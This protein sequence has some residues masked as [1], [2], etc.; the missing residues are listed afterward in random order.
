VR[1]QL[2]NNGAIRTFDNEFMERCGLISTAK[3]KL[4]LRNPSEGAIYVLYGAAKFHVPNWDTLTRLFDGI[5]IRD[6]QGGELDHIGTMPGDG[7]LLHEETTGKVFV[8]YGAAKFH[9]P[10]WD[11]L[12]RLFPGFLLRPL[13]AGALDHIPDCPADGTFFREESSTQIYIIAGCHKAPAKTPAVPTEA[14]HVLWDGALAQI[15]VGIDLS[16]LVPLL[17]SDPVLTVASPVPPW[18]LLGG[19]LLGGALSPLHR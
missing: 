6:V 14:V 7:T 8:I 11:T 4:L 18:E 12:T 19:G 9:V 3:P 1:N 5:P 15:P 2:T 10:N 13:W 17:L 16:F